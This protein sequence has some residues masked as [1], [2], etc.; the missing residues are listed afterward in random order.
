MAFFAIFISIFWC[1]WANMNI[2]CS[3][4]FS[5]CCIYIWTLTWLMHTIYIIF[6]WFFFYYNFRIETV[7]FLQWEFAKFNIILSFA[8]YISS[9]THNFYRITLKCFIFTFPS[10]SAGEKKNSISTHFIWF[11]A[12][13]FFIPKICGRW[14][15]KEPMFAILFIE[16]LFWI[17]DHI[18]CDECF[19][20]T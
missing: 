4:S 1:I 19:Q 8:S 17:V 18:K 12:A 20:R 6:R 7:C 16:E 10:S 14:T 3:F 11:V 13:K 9:L 2:S 5:F 15:R